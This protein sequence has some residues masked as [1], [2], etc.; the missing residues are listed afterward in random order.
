M[1]GRVACKVRVWQ[2][3]MWIGWECRSV[4]VVRGLVVAE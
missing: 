3:E 4:E 1:W 2:V